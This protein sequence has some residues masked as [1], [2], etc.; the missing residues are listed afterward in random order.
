MVKAQ[1]CMRR[2]CQWG[3][4]F[5]LFTEGFEHESDTGEL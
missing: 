3:A 2:V 4:W 5:L 1:P